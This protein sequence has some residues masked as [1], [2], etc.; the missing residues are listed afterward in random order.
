MINV[1]VIGYGYWGPNLVRN[2]HQSGLTKL[3]AV[4]DIREERLKEVTTRYPEVIATT[5]YEDLID[6][7]EIDAIVV[8][9]PVESHYN[10]AK[11][12]LE[13]DKHVLVEKPLTSTVSEAKELVKIAKEK[14]KILMVD[15]TFLYL[16]ETEKLR[17]LVSS[18]ELGDIY[19]ISMQR[20]S[21]GLF[22]R[23]VNV[24][25]D[26]M[27]HDIALLNYILGYKPITVNTAAAY[28]CV[29]KGRGM[30]DTAH[31]VLQ[32][33]NASIVT[34]HVSWVHPEKKRVLTIVGSKKMAVCDFEN[35]NHPI[36][37][38]NKGADNY[39]PFPPPNTAEQHNLV[40]YRDQEIVIP[41]VKGNGEAL[42]GVVVEFAKAIT[43]NRKPKTDGEEGLAVVQ[44][45]D[46]ALQSMR[47]GRKVEIKY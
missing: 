21:L 26:L 44:V 10:L 4:S 24:I 13:K 8:A 36:M 19:T 6:N 43:E 1:G 7:P 23:T 11:E 42:N 5:N 2:F 34:A 20:V 25:Q 9:T 27:P 40:H 22:Q 16:A 37:I 32:Y 33:P 15:H 41:P 39:T 31:I 18:G 47:E 12:A 28:A 17:E 14:G 30:E 35:R 38:Y 3:V 45:L 46:A 29:G